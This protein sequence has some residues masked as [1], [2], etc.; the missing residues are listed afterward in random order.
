MTTTSAEAMSSLALGASLNPLAQHR[1]LRRRQHRGSLARQR[2]NK[3]ATLQS[4][5]PQLRMQTLRMQRGIL[6]G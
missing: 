6:C 3:A 5:V 2:P 4:L 1:Q